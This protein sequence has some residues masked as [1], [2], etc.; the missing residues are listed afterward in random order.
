VEVSEIL[1]SSFMRF[2]IPLCKK[3]LLVP[4]QASVPLGPIVTPSNVHR[5]FWPSMGLSRRL[6]W[7]ATFLATLPDVRVVTFFPILLVYSLMFV[8]CILDVVEMTNTM[9]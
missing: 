3:E 8:P 4:G 9:H 5:Y 2:V 7:Q 6:E 1:G